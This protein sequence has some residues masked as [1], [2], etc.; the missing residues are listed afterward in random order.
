MQK[1]FNSILAFVLIATLLCSLTMPNTAFA[2][3]IT[4][5]ND[6]AKANPLLS[7]SVSE[8]SNDA[9]EANSDLTIASA[10]SNLETVSELRP[11]EEVEAL[12][13]NSEVLPID[14]ASKVLAMKEAESTTVVLEDAVT[15][16]AEIL[17][18]DFK[19]SEDEASLPDSDIVDESVQRI[20]EDEVKVFNSADETEKSSQIKLCFVPEL[21]DVYMV[22]ASEAALNSMYITDSAGKTIVYS[23]SW[24]EKSNSVAFK[25]YKGC[26]YYINAYVNT[27][28]PVEFLVNKFVSIQ[29]EVIYKIKNNTYTSEDVASVAVEMPCLP[30]DI[31]AGALQGDIVFEAELLKNGISIEKIEVPKACIRGGTGTPEDNLLQFVCNFGVKV[32]SGEYSIKI[33]CKDID[34]KVVLEECQASLKIGNDICLYV[35]ESSY[36]VSGH[37][38][39]YFNDIN[40]SEG[41]FILVDETGKTIGS[42][43]NVSITTTDAGAM[44]FG[45]KYNYTS[46]EYDEE[47][48]TGTLYYANIPNINFN[49]LL[50]SDKEYRLKLVAGVSQFEVPV[51]V[52]PT[53]ELIVES[54]SYNSLY[55]ATGDNVQYADLNVSVSN[56]KNVDI[57]NINFEIMDMYGNIVAS[58]VE[59]ITYSEN[60]FIYRLKVNKT[61][62]QYDKYTIRISYPGKLYVNEQQLIFNSYNVYNRL[63][64]QY[65]RIVDY[66][67]PII[68][69]VTSYCDKAM[70]YKVELIRKDNHIP[71]LIGELSGVRP[72]DEGVFKLDFSGKSEL[73]LLNEGGEYSIVFSDKIGG[74]YSIMLSNKIGTLSSIDFNVPASDGASSVDQFITFY[75]PMLPKTGTVEFALSGYGIDNGIMGTENVDIELVG[76][77]EVYGSV[78]KSTIKKA[79]S[80]YMASPYYNTEQVMISG[81][82]NISKELKEDTKYFIRING[83]EYEYFYNTKDKKLNINALKIEDYNSFSSTSFK[84]LEGKSKVAYRMYNNEE[85]DLSCNWVKGFSDNAELLLVDVMTKEE[86]HAGLWNTVNTYYE[87]AFKDIKVEADLT[88]AKTEQV[89]E[90][91]LKDGDEKFSFNKYIVFPA[92]YPASSFTVQKA[93]YGSDML[94]L[95]FSRTSTI[96]GYSFNVVD[97]L[98]NIISCTEVDERITKDL[99]IVDLKLDTELNYGKYSICMYDEKNVRRSQ[100]IVV[101]QE[102][103][104]PSVNSVQYGS[105]TLLLGENLE[106]DAEYIAD[107]SS[108]WPYINV[109]K[110]IKLVKRTGENALEINQR[111]LD[112]LMIGNYYVSVKADGEIIGN[113]YLYYNGSLDIKPMIIAKEWTDGSMKKPLLEDKDVSFDINTLY[114]TKVRF[115]EK[116]DDLDKEDYQTVTDSVYYSF[117]ASQG[118]KTL[119][120]QLIDDFDTESEV[121]AFKAYLSENRPDI[122]II[123]PEEGAMHAT[124][125]KVVANISG[126]PSF[127]GVA[128]Y[129]EGYSGDKVSYYVREARELKPMDDK[130]NY[131]TVLEYSAIE[132]IEKVEVFT[133]DEVGNITSSKSVII[134]KPEQVVTPVSRIDI[135]LDNKDKHDYVKISGNTTNGEGNVTVYAYK[136]YNSYQYNSWASYS[137]KL[138]ANEKGDFEGVLNIP[139]NGKYR[140]VAQDFTGQKSYSYD[141][142]VDT[143]APVLKDYDTV[144]QSVDSVKLSWDVKDDNGCSYTIWKDGKL[145]FSGYRSK[146]YIATGLNKG[147]TYVYKIMAT[148]VSGNTSE[149][150]QIVVEV[151]DE[152]VPEVP[153]NLVVSSH[154]SKSISLS[155]QASSDNSVVAG[156]EIFRD[157]TKIAVSYSNSYT[158]SKLE[159]GVEYSYKI[160]AFDPSMNYSD[161]GETIK[162]TPVLNS[163]KDA[164]DG[165]YSFV[166]YNVKK[167]ELKALTSDILNSSDI[168]VKFEYRYGEEDTWVYFDNSSS[169]VKTPEGLLFKCLWN[170]E[171]LPQGDYTIRYTA[172]DR[173]GAE[174]EVMSEAISILEV[175]DDVNPEIVAI[176][177]DASCYTGNIPVVITARDNISL[178]EIEL[179]TSLDGSEWSKAM[180]TTL[181]NSKQYTWRY[182]LNISTVREG[183]FYVRAIATDV[184]GN[185]SEKVPYTQYIIDNTAP[186]KVQNVTAISYADCIEIRW[187]K[188]SEP[189]IRSFS[190][191]RSEEVSGLYTTIAANVVSL[192]YFDT[193]VEPGKTYY[194]KVI[195]ND[196]AG[197]SSYESNPVKITM[198]DASGIEDNEKPVVTNDYPMDK[199]TIGSKL[200]Y[201][202]IASDNI[203]LSKLGAEYSLDGKEWI[204]FFAVPSSYQKY[205]YTADLDTKAFPSGS[206]LKIRG[207][208][209]D[210]KGNVSDYV[211]SEYTIDNIAPKGLE[212]VVEPVG[213]GFNISW[214]CDE[215]DIVEYEL[216][217]RTSDSEFYTVVGEYRA[218]TLSL[219]D[220]DLDPSKQYIYKII[221]TDKLINTAEALS[222]AISPLDID[223]VLPTPHINCVSSAELGMEVEFDAS[224]SKDNVGITKYSWNFGDGTL[225]ESAKVSHIYTVEGEYK[226]VLSVEDSSGNKSSI[227]KSITILKKDN[228]GSLNITVKDNTGKYIPYANIYVNL[229]TEDQFK[230]STDM[231][232]TVTLK[233]EPGIYDIGAYQ[234]G[235]SPEQQDILLAENEESNLDFV[236]EETKIVVGDI[237]TTKLSFEEIK[238]AGIDVYAPGNQN[239]FRYEINLNYNSKPYT[240]SGMYSGS[241]HSSL[242][243]SGLGGG[244]V[245]G[246]E[247]TPIVSRNRSTGEPFILLIDVPGR[248]TW[249]KEF[250]D[251]KLHLINTEGSYDLENCVATLNLPEGVSIASDDEQSVSIG[252]IGAKESKTLNWIIRGDAPGNYNISA[253]FNGLL[254]SF[255]EPVKA[256]FASNN[257]I[258]VN[259]SSGLKLIVE[260]EE[261]K[262]GN[263]DLLYRVGFVNEKSSAIYL[264]NINMSNSTFIRSYKTRA[265]MSLVKT[266]YS[267]LLPGEILWKEY[268]L[269]SELYGKYAD[270]RLFMKELTSTALGGLKMPIETR[271]VEFGTFG[272]LKT[273]IYVL[274]GGES[275]VVNQL[276]LTKYKSKENDK[277]PDLMIVTGR[278]ISKDNIVHEKSELIIKD[279]IKDTTN[280]IK[281]D[282]KGTYIYSGYSIDDVLVEED[283]ISYFAI[284]VTSSDPL[285]I[286]SRQGV[287]IIDQKLLP[288]DSFG[289]ISGKVINKDVNKDIVDAD[290]T[291]GENKTKTNSFGRFEFNDILFEDDTI[292]IEAEGFPKKTVEGEMYDG[293]YFKVELERMPEV[294]RVT[295]YIS[296]SFN[297]SCSILPL[298]L[299]FGSLS[300]TV[301]VDL[302]G[303]GEVSKYL[304]KI[305]DRYGRTKYTGESETRYIEVE[306]IRSKMAQG[307]RILFAIEAVGT[308]GTTT[309]DYLDAKIVMAREFPFLNAVSWLNEL[310]TAFESVGEFDP[311]GI[312]GALKFATGEGVPDID[313]PS[314]SGPIKSIGLDIPK[315]DFDLDVKYDFANGKATFTSK[316][317][318][319]SGLSGTLAEFDVPKPFSAAVGTGISTSGEV[320]FTLICVYND[321]TLKWEIEKYQIQIASE[322]EVK[323]ITLEFKYNVPIDAYFGGVLLSGYV[324]LE[325]NG[326]V[327]FFVNVGIDDIG[328]FDSVQDLMVDFYCIIEVTLRAAI[329]LEVAY[330]LVGGEFWAEGGLN[331]TVPSGKTVLSLAIGFKETVAWFISFE[332]EI[333]RL[334]WV[335][336]DPEARPAQNVENN[337]PAMRS[338]ERNLEKRSVKREAYSAPAVNSTTSEEKLFETSP[339]DYLE[340]QKWI[341]EEEI[342]QYAY[343]QSDAKISEIKDKDE[344]LLMVFV[345]DD[346]ERSD[347]NRTALYYSFFKEGKWSEPKQI[348]NDG[349]ADAFPNISA[350][351]KNTYA[352]WLDMDEKI[353]DLS[354]VTAD[355]IIKNILSKMKL[356]IAKFDQE[357]AIWETEASLETEGLNKLPQIATENGKTIAAW[358]NNYGKVD[359]GTKENP[360]DIYFV[361]NNG[362]GWT[363][364]KAFVTNAQ[365]VNKSDLLLHNGKAYFVYTT[366]AYSQDGQFKLYSSV[367]DGEKWSKPK[368]VLD[369]MYNDTHPSIA[370]ENGKPVV[371]FQNNS[372]I[373]KAEIESGNNDIVVNSDRAYGIQE[374]QATNTDEGI[375]LAWTNASEGEQRLFISTYDDES[376]TWTQGMELKHNSMEIPRNITLAGNGNEV[377]AVYN[378][379]VY[380]KEEDELGYQY[381]GTLLTSTSYVRKIDMAIPVDGILVEDEALAPGEKTYVYVTVE[382]VGDLTAKNNSVALYDGEKLIGTETINNSMSHGSRKTVGFEY[383]TSTDCKELKL[384][385]EVKTTND[386]DISN[387]TSY[388]NLAFADIAIT[389]IINEL[390]EK[391]RGYAYIDV[392]NLGFTVFDSAKLELYTDKEFKNLIATKEIKKIYPSF[393]KKTAVEFEV[394]DEQVKER[395]RL[396]AKVVVDQAESDYKNNSDFTVVRPLGFADGTE[397]VTPEPTPVTPEPTPVTPEPTPVTPEPTPVTPE[398][399]PVTPEPTPATPGVTP[400]AP[401]KTPGNGGNGSTGSNSSGSG[402][403]SSSGGSDTVP[404]VT[405]TPV[406]DTTPTTTPTPDTTEIPETDIPG[407]NVEQKGYMKGYEDNS[408]RPDN[409]IT[410]AEMAAILANLDKVTNSG[411]DIMTFKDVDNKHW[412]AWAIKYVYTKGYFKGYEDNSFRPDSYITRAEM[413]VVLCKYLKLSGNAGVL[414]ELTDTKGHWA[415][416]YINTLTTKGYIKGYSDKTFK[417][418]NKIKRSECA[419]LINRALGLQLEGTPQSR[420]KDVDKAH[421]AFSDIA[422]ATKE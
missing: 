65:V 62:V 152:A 186:E 151:G 157:G 340:K 272:R 120:F 324:S 154:A 18:T 208:A 50:Q 330:G 1:R 387:N 292:T 276:T 119:Y 274:K 143:V 243:G 248:V 327:T 38:N 10:T 401:G 352:I 108:S 362:S 82:L 217:R 287:R 178:R 218:T 103:I 98:D 411:T 339:R 25:L 153:Q 21:T 286:G 24:P 67:T 288:K 96:E 246:R 77:G 250:F 2:E 55:E 128:F 70:E 209:V 421:W 47:N 45:S 17:N 28:L 187:D 168:T 159:T 87:G 363:E 212:I 367:F 126:N 201:V 215:T 314:D 361:Y 305:V 188:N 46:H 416:S 313:M 322:I 13:F 72:D 140:L 79:V 333:G 130:G 194:Y 184:S 331:I 63:T 64:T 95:S 141:I 319:S 329:G 227:E 214:S 26:K 309:S 74:E 317:S 169:Y 58:K 91:C 342:M 280:T 408:F 199:M 107:I 347:N 359:V 374:L 343:P 183:E 336:Y 275:S 29:T 190:V 189:Y 271:M 171:Y 133:A 83:M 298:N 9:P 198:L 251:V 396:Y 166:G 123:T 71:M 34:S 415:E 383:Q 386:G 75:P 278:G 368:G 382:N 8:V 197:N 173:D 380:K 179:Q 260:V 370:L 269:D 106:D 371:F 228:S 351:S 117:D 16:K 202:L 162:H 261:M 293:R 93:V 210:L 262:K 356:R 81:T 51:K 291:Y 385:A 252:T 48:F 224:A 49:G 326:K 345:G 372:V 254:E 381:D 296:D 328:S 400:T 265:D 406:P 357:K 219:I 373:Y 66:N 223:D 216:H 384:K 110:G 125:L 413:A 308:Y 134:K 129:S 54:V 299:P 237:K 289:T 92:N 337:A 266:S 412:A 112:S 325:I 375:A 203:K 388:R 40:A 206:I 395:V 127:A 354:K 12:R 302:K 238:A 149:P 281:T 167:V 99:R 11:T 7:K 53:E 86:I 249:L 221:A 392:T 398:P 122:S 88:K 220:K 57:E 207:Y 226:V 163:I 20:I 312:D 80:V 409:N 135:K 22:T 303:A 225:K 73:P 138:L 146:L 290:V 332:Q 84:D 177:P 355:Y 390:Y 118:E 44:V 270:S 405:P 148:D 27:E 419:A 285:V 358:V 164:Y 100:D 295:S 410:R 417:P 263:V 222:E 393:I 420:F 236:L 394:T 304:Y 193:S 85:L 242:G 160:R 191:L 245:G 145:L 176:K 5:Q 247:I 404:Q 369:N 195:C 257:P 376:S 181:Y 230:V 185:V 321:S 277:M 3:G 346:K 379:S 264:P 32:E 97:S 150:V 389:R 338:S 256:T 318:G 170:V 59:H 402:N 310:E 399:T 365:N 78:E 323:I 307:D 35:P 235:Y 69:V 378:K 300:F 232:G 315:F 241:S 56:S 268:T 33:N 31:V 104:V 136:Y 174:Q 165:S 311:N 115:A 273:Q 39:V 341:G 121:Y 175:E 137:V 61:I 124:D 144:A 36:Y 116:L 267:S 156:Y 94:T 68:E 377:L 229:N 101:T 102:K 204:E 15:V 41:K 89:Y 109:K 52:V 205:V 4:T 114:Y 348:E 43:A 422:I 306:D 233:L 258:V 349:T 6:V 397:T 42:S 155:W 37:G 334:E 259:N 19:H 253:D 282:D 244:S 350:D 132:Y 414:S 231:N 196:I 283:G 158:D 211:Y 14:S 200:T 407:S 391:N 23:R 30:A 403:S 131:S 255:N 192:N 316:A 360:D 60:S 240:V 182:N 234:E 320:T 344:D 239:V 142:I 294:T 90:I 279:G 213:R 353:G 364:P 113:V 105:P 418:D 335:V 297:P 111:D 366:D 180:S 76:E 147:Q 284:D 301:T 139:V 161:F 172:V